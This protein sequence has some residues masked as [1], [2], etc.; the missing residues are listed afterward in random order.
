MGNGGLDISSPAALLTSADELGFEAALDTPMKDVLD[1]GDFTVRA[2]RLVSSLMVSQGCPTL[3][4]LLTTRK[5]WNALGARLSAEVLE[6]LDG[7]LLLQPVAGAM[8]TEVAAALVAH[9]PAP[10]AE[11]KAAKA[12]RAAPATVIAPKVPLLAGGM[13]ADELQEWAASRNVTA[14]L[15]R[16]CRVLDDRVSGRARYWFWQGSDMRIEDIITTRPSRRSGAMPVE[17]QDAAIEWLRDR[18]ARVERALSDEQKM[19]AMGS[20][21]EEP[22]LRALWD[23][24]AEARAVIREHTVPAPMDEVG[25][26]RL[27]LQDDPPIWALRDGWPALC[28]NSG[29]VKRVHLQALPGERLLTCECHLPQEACPLALVALDTLRVSMAMPR[30]AERSWL[31][32][33][34]GTPAWTRALRDLDALLALST[35]DADDVTLGWRVDLGVRTLLPLSCRPRKRGTGYK[36]TKMPIE[37]LRGRPDRCVLPADDEVRAIVLAER[38]DTNRG[39]QSVFP[40]LA[41]LVG[42]PRVFIGNEP[43]TVRRGRIEM[44][45]TP[46]EEGG[47]R[48][49]VR[50]GGFVRD[51][52][53]LLAALNLSARDGWFALQD[54][55]VITTF[56]VD[57]AAT[58]LLGTLV[59]RGG[60]FP[61]EATAGLLARLTPL[62]QKVPAHLAPELRGASQAPEEK[63]VVRLDTLAEG[64]LFVQVLVR[65]L[66]GALAF[67]PG[68][69]PE[70]LH[71]QIGDN[72]VHVQ[73]AL[74]AE[75]VRVRAALA[76]LQLPADC[77]AP[78][79]SWTILDPE[80]GLDVVTALQASRDAFAVEWTDPA[81][82]RGTR[83]AEAK[84]LS[85]KVKTTRDWFGIEGAVAVE[86][87]SVDL[88]AVLA[89]VLAGRRYVAVDANTWIKLGDRLTEQLAG[90]ADAIHAGRAGLEVPA[91]AVPLVDALKDAGAAIDAPAGWAD[92]LDRVRAA[93]GYDPELPAGFTAE[94][95]EYQ[96]AGFRWLARLATWAPG[97]CLADDMGL[98][99]TVQ[100]LAL[101]A[102]RA[103]GGPALVVA[104]TSVGFNWTR[105]AARF[106]PTLRVRMYRG[107]GRKALL[108]D[109]GPNDVLVTSWDLLPRDALALSPVRF[110]TIVLDEAQAMK[111]A[112]TARAKA[113]AGLTSDFRLAL[114][115]T[116]VEN[117]VSELW[118]LFRVIAPGLFGSWE[119]FRD[120][121]ATAIERDGDPRRRKALARLI[122]PFLLRRLKSQVATELPQRSDVNVEIVLSREERSLY[123]HARIALLDDLASESGPPEQ[124]RFKVL[125][126]L[127]RLRQLSCHP[128]LLDPTSTLP[129]AKLTRL[130]ELVAELRSEGHRALVFSQFTRHLALVREALT[131]DGVSLRYLDGSTPEA[132]RRAEVDA[133]QGGAGEVFLISLKAG[134]TGLNL[135]AA[136]Y[137]IH[138]DPWWNPAVEDQASDRA[139]RIGQTQPVTVY[140]LVARG[141]IEEQILALHADKRELVA[142]LLDGSGAA[143]TMKTDELLALL[144]AGDD[145]DDEGEDAGADVGAVEA[146]VVPLVEALVVVDAPVAA[147]PAVVAPLAEA[148]R[149]AVGEANPVDLEALEEAYVEAFDL[150]VERGDKAEGT[151]RAYVRVV[152]RFV[153]WASAT[154]AVT[155]VATL[156]SALAAFLAEESPGSV[157]RSA[158][159]RLRATV[160]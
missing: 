143:A 52:V 77:E 70:Q 10:V 2:H 118:S 26:T 67:T 157:G 1:T 151:M 42:H 69:G 84:N 8:A 96:R 139:H 117:R 152:T 43:V 103:S 73:R 4:A 17:V 83:A 150:A 113:A 130:R 38:P 45:W 5:V 49:G 116:P 15:Q 61:A 158:L 39:N 58:A 101:L 132:Q 81:R 93:E 40:T 160:G 92:M 3:R 121:F 30:A 112:G 23:R 20:V 66:A 55:D 71:A 32:E 137:V 9:A 85:I 111:N 62:A 29:A 133:F 82:R 41:R 120:R 44:D 63:P 18:V 78:L 19:L 12:P 33:M 122:R 159:R 21:P 59:R 27:V 72:R 138:L 64:G 102:H 100:A 13:P 123:D 107:A 35:P 51:P 153:S 60:V 108:D 6:T 47:V 11:P 106:A 119:R 144:Q 57:P 125:A 148:A 53:Q 94:L 80:V 34:L 65:P 88:A 54:G 149:A 24:V 115:G 46:T 109:L 56:P 89:A 135:T 91:L 97:A 114:T 146:P 50:V 86:E 156:D 75:P 155:T 68:E 134:G 99:K 141:T 145:A 74:A 98:G 16:H 104:P 124:Q 147:V 142:G 37:E 7:W 87:A 90:V 31:L 154:H 25:R 126:A 105:E 129:S 48:V 127:T 128:R 140:R 110:A 79:F 131:A 28:S 36:L 136:T 76:P 14:E 95:R 22:A